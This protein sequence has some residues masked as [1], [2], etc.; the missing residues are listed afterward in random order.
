MNKQNEKS[1]DVVASLKGEKLK[2][3]TRLV[4][5]DTNLPKIAINHN[6]PVKAE[7]KSEKKQLKLKT[8]LVAGDTNLPKIA[9]NHNG[10]VL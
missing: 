7:A 10:R 5:G 8:R 2:L 1:I 4:A 9:I 6:P 3:K